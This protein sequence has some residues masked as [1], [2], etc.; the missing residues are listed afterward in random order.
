MNL[1]DKIHDLKMAIQESNEWVA[2]N[3]FHAGVSDCLALIKSWEADLAEHLSLQ[4]KLK[5]IKF[6]NK[7]LDDGLAWFSQRP[8][9]QEENMVEI[10]NLTARE[11]VSLEQEVDSLKEYLNVCE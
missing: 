8:G 5:R 3:A 11:I 1:S 6:L 7:K 9:V 10:N 4:K 2:E